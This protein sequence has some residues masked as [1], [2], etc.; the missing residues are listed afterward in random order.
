MC[1][2]WEQFISGMVV[3]FTVV[4]NDGFSYVTI[5]IFLV[6]VPR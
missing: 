4:V 2:E 5:F 6:R 3:D 1:F